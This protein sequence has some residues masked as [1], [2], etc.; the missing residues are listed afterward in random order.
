MTKIRKMQ[1]QDIEQVAKIEKLVFSQPWSYQSIYESFIRPEYIFLVAIYNQKVIGY[2]GLYTVLSEGDI[3]NIAVLPEYRNKGIAKSL[4][5]RLFAE[6]MQKAKSNISPDNHIT[7]SM[8]INLEVRESNSAAIH[9]YK[10]LGFK[11]VGV[12]KNFYDKPKE[13]AIL[14]TSLC[15]N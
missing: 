12:R 6:A 1:E 7:L 10:S 13:N 9:L 2:V 8:Q 14:M 15:I 3:T 4:L 5:N 11:T